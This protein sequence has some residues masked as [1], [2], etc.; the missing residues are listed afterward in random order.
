MRAFHAFQVEM[1][2]FHRKILTRYGNSLV[3]ILAMFVLPILDILLL[4]WVT[5]PKLVQLHLF[6]KTSNLL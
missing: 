6:R 3:V 5:I 4:T 2:A 1:G